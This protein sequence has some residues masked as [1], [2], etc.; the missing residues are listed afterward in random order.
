MTAKYLIFGA[1]GSIG[2]SLVNQLKKS[3][4][5]NIHLVARNNADVKKFN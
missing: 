4:H 1:T 2:S 5:D 3:G